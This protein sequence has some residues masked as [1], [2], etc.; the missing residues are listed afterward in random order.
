VLFAWPM[1]L[2]QQGLSCDLHP[3]GGGL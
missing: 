1:L 3:H 2:V